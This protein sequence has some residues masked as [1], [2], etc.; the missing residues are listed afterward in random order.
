MMRN[1]RSGNDFINYPIAGSF[2]KFL[3]EEYGLETVKITWKGGVF[4]LTQAIGYGLDILET[5]WIQTIQN[6]EIESI[7]YK[8][9]E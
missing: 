3:Y 5:K 7:Q 6:Y 4:A 1:F 8:Y 9:Y 2:I